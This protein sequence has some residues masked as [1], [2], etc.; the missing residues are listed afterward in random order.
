MVH[1]EPD[2]ATADE[3]SIST[4]PPSYNPSQAPTVYKVGYPQ[5]KNLATEFTNALRETFFHDNPLKQYKDQPGSTKLKM[6]L[7]FLFPV[8]DWG[9]TYNLNKFKGD[10]IA[11]LTIAS[12]CIPQVSRLTDITYS[13]Y[14]KLFILDFLHN[15]YYVSRHNLYLGT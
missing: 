15:F 1:H 3:T 13:L 14:S 8:F 12:L 10:L 11:G 7:Q 2:E 4:Q 6:G 9:R 5:K